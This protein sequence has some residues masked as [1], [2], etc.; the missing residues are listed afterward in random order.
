MIR[1]SRDVPRSSAIT[2]LTVASCLRCAD[3]VDWLTGTDATISRT[4]IGFLLRAS[5]ETICTRVPSA[6]AMNHAA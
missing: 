2:N 4:V 5:S 6:S 1:Y 3:T